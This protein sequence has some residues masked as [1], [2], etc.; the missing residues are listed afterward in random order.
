MILVPALFWGWLT[1]RAPYRHTPSQSIVVD[2]AET[3]RLQQLAHP[4]VRY[5]VT[6]S[7]SSAGL[8]YSNASGGTE[9][10]EVAL[11]WRTSFDGTPGQHLYLSAQNKDDSGTVR[12]AISVNGVEAKQA[13]SSGAYAIAT[14]NGRL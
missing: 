1:L 10:R 7:A 5:E 3:K 14:A 4:E 11:P 8:T 6:G 9:Q 2:P 12:V 13:E